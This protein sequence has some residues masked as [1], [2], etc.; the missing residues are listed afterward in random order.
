MASSESNHQKSVHTRQMVASAMMSAIICVT[1]LIAIPAG[2][3]SGYVHFGDCFIILGAAIIG[4]AY[5]CIA[6]I[7]GSCLADFILGY[8]VYIPATFV[9]KGIM[10]LVSSGLFAAA[11]VEV[12][13]HPGRNHPKAFWRRVADIAYSGAAAEL[14]MIFGYYLYD[15]LLFGQVAALADVPGNF[16]QC[17]FGIAT[18]LIFGSI[19]E[20][21]HLR[22]FLHR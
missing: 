10:A 4:P 12:F 9:I 18:A 3:T 20:K 7:I 6:A 8:V 14:V 15:W 19:F 5:G 17:C 13:P 2:A 1:T 11:R 16:L 22:Q 21:I